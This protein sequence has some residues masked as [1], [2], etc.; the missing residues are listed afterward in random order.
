VTR[1]RV[2]LVQVWLAGIA[3]APLSCSSLHA[4]SHPKTVAHPPAQAKD[5][6]QTI[7]VEGNQRIEIATIRSYMGVQLGAPFDPGRLDRI[8]KTLYATG[9]F[10]DVRLSREGN[11][12]SVRVVENPLINSVAFEGNHILTGDQLR[13]EELLPRAVFTPSLAE[14]DR[15]RII[16]I[17]A[18]YSYYHTSIEHQIIHLYNNLVDIVVRVHEGPQAHIRRIAFKG[19]RVYG[20]DHLLRQINSR[21]EG[22]WAFLSNADIYSPKNFIS[23]QELLRRFYLRNG[24]VDFEVT[25]AAAVTSE[26]ESDVE[27]ISLT[28]ALHEGERY[29]V[30][31][32]AITSQLPTINSDDL[33]ADLQIAEGDWYDADAI[34]R[35]A[36]AIAVRV[37]ARGNSFVEVR[38][39]VN[40]DRAREAIDVGFDVEPGPNVYIERVDIAGNTRTSDSVIRRQFSFAEGDPFSAEA[41]RSSV[42]RVEHLRYFTSVDIKPTPGLSPDRTVLV[43]TVVER[44]FS[45]NVTL[46]SIWQIVVAVAIVLVIAGMLTVRSPP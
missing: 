13:E 26:L 30:N 42:R 6:I 35:S 32:I 18:K 10:Q 5:T 28:L 39:R 23:D 37:R 16:K 15:Q 41:V 20:E 17:Y 44:P 24:Y 31:K 12:L 11:T 1:L 14:T 45:I 2:C 36:D 21:P 46:P 3:A 9:L 7:K 33:R 4:Q 29:R 25:D 22:W 38:P 27:S 40:R 43:T 34:D 19:N 8:L